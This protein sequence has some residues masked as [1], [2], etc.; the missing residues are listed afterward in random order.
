MFLTTNLYRAVT[1]PP[2]HLLHIR[3]GVVARREHSIGHDDILLVTEVQHHETRNVWHQAFVLT[4]PTARRL[5][6]EL[7]VHV[8]DAPSHGSLRDHDDD[9]PM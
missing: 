4:M 6:A 7:I 1:E 5:A 3:D 2:A 9:A 8:E